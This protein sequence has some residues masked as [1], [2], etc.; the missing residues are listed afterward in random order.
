MHICFLS[1]EYPRQGVT[2]GGIGTF[3]LTICQALVKGGHKVTVIGIYGSKDL[4]ENLNGVRVVTF[5]RS[6]AKL[7]SW[8]RNFSRISD[9]L[10]VLHR[11][12]PIDLIEGSELTFAFVRKLKNVPCVIRLHGGHHF[13]AEGENRPLNRWK[14]LQEKQSFK[15]ADAFIAVSEYVKVHTGKLLSFHGKPVKVINYPVS[16]DK[17]YKADPSKSIPYRLVFAGTVCEKKGIRQLIQA[18]P[19]VAKTYPEV[20]LE[21]YG[22]D[23]LFPDGKSYMQYLKEIFPKK[24]LERVRFHGPVSHEDLPKYYEEAE[25]CVFPSHMETQG[26]VAPEAMGMGKPVIFSKTGPGP[27][28]ID[29]GV[30]GWLC[31]PK[32]PKSISNAILEAFSQ[33]SSFGKIGEAAI[34]K[35]HLK[36]DPDTI[37]RQNL[38]FY[39]TLI[40]KP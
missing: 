8:W 9:F 1:Q 2:Y 15:K 30:N 11:S 40:Q 28:T 6:Q 7:I 20:H 4:D 12:Q 10:E 35:A 13:F 26:L 5:G 14:A 39:Q 24:D 36:F 17:F 23:W 3:L 25:I 37:T 16:F 22:R 34:K 33:R 38:E 32:D 31:D 21:V 19:E 29:H 18:L 27:E